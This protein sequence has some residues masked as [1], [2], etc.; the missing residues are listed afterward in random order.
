MKISLKENSDFWLD[1]WKTKMTEVDFSLIDQ[2]IIDHIDKLKLKPNDHILVPLCGKSKTLLWLLKEGYTVTG[3]EL[4]PIAC[5]NFFSEMGIKP[6]IFKN[7]KFIKYKYKQLEIICA[8]FFK[9]EASDLTKVNAIYDCNAIIALPFDLQKKYIQHLKTF[10][11][12]Q[13]IILLISF[14]IDTKII[15]PPFMVKKTDLEHYFG[16]N[17]QVELIQ[18]KK[19]ALPAHLR[20]LGIYDK[21]D[22]IYLIQ[23]K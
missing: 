23:S 6:S 15:G 21:I 12:P 13:T 14:E 22:T 2:I 3:I 20:Q 8:D 19:S 1:F 5:M 4:S 16:K 7:K 11:H 18:E 10:V 17:F 9:L